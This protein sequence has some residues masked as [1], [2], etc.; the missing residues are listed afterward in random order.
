MFPD[1]KIEPH[2]RF[3]DSSNNTVVTRYY[4]L[5]YL[6]KVAAIDICPNFEH[7]LFWGHCLGPLFGNIGNLSQL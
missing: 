5:E 4:S 7:C 1:S 6:D 3:W 2:I